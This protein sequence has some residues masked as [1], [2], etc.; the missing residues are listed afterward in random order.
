MV[1]LNIWAYIF[2]ASVIICLLQAIF[3]IIMELGIAVGNLI[4][5]IFLSIYN[6]IL[7]LFR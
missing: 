2:V 7:N 4:D 3:S 1:L 5:R 6:F